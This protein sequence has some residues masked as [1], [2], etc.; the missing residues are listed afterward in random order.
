MLVQSNLAVINT[1]L[2]LR[3]CHR[4]GWHPKIPTLDDQKWSLLIFTPQAVERLVEYDYGATVFV[5]S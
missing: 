2:L 4:L 3:K 1:N 5:S